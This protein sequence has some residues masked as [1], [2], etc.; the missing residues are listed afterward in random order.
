[1]FSDPMSI[2]PFR[3]A[4]LHPKKFGFAKIIVPVIGWFP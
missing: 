2:L 1:M 3:R 4:W